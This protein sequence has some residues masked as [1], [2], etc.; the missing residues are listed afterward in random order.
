MELGSS[1][2]KPVIDPVTLGPDGAGEYYL[3]WKGYEG[4]L[5]G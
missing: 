5:I 1:D 2:P 3:Q 4:N